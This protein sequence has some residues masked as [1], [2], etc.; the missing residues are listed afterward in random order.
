MFKGSNKSQSN[1]RVKG[2]LVGINY[3]GTRNQLGGCINDALAVQKLILSNYP[4]AD[5]QLLTDDT[6]EKPTRDNILNKLKQLVANA[7]AGDTLIF[8]YSGHGSQ[9]PDI[10]GDEEDGLDETICPIDFMTR[11]VI[12]YKGQRITLDSQITDDEINEIISEVPHGARFLMLADSCHSGTIGDLNNDFDHYHGPT[13]WPNEECANHPATPLLSSQTTT[14]NA[15]GSQVTPSTA[16]YSYPPVTESTAAYSYPSATPSTAAYSHSSPHH[17]SSSVHQSVSS[18]IS[19]AASW[20]YVKLSDREELWLTPLDGRLYSEFG[21]KKYIIPIDGYSVIAGKLLECPNRSKVSPTNFKK[22]ANGQYEVSSPELGINS[23]PVNL[24]ATKAI[25]NYINIYNSQFG[26]P[27]QQQNTGSGVA[28]APVNT[29][30]PPQQTHKPSWLQSL[31][32]KSVAPGCQVSSH[33][34]PKT[35]QHYHFH[36]IT[37]KKRSLSMRSP[38]CA[39]GELRIISGCREDETSADT[40]RNG[41][42]TMAF[43]DTV[44]LFGGLPNFLTKIFSHNTEDFK[45]IENSIN[46]YLSSFGFTQHSVFSWDHSTSERILPNEAIANYVA[47]YNNAAQLSGIQNLSSNIASLT[48]IIP[49]NVSD[50]ATASAGLN[51]RRQSQEATLAGLNSR[52]QSQEATIAATNA[53]TVLYR[54]PVQREQIDDYVKN[55]I[56]L[57]QSSTPTEQL[58]TGIA[59]YRTSNRTSRNRYKTN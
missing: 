30:T 46:K 33:Y 18:L 47:T 10:H 50:D 6:P 56:S 58:T 38:N 54:Y 5:L 2:L 55:A 44:K 21:N 16:A 15:P 8:D 25:V 22:L 17:Y 1:G 20:I 53:A 12:N 28:P 51:S 37:G 52:R 19:S 32:L 42:C 29:A 34:N 14:G 27:Y 7:K 26:V 57:M 24:G 39:G 9:V 4:A 45:L 3:R 36:H 48:A 41:A 43:L 11:R 13:I 59:D 49:D 31:H 35:G 23:I 40:G